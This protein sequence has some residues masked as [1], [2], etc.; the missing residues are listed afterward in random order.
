MT[1]WTVVYMVCGIFRQATEHTRNILQVYW[2]KNYNIRR[3][4]HDIYKRTTKSVYNSLPDGKKQKQ[5]P[6]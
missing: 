1:L 5:D 3:I 4:N 6:C 2:Y